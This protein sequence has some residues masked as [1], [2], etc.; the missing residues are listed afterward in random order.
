M[1]T[2]DRM[3]AA[4]ALC[5]LLLVLWPAAGRSAD[6]AAVMP[7]SSFPRE[8]IAVETR[9]AKRHVFTAWRATTPSQREQ[10]LMFVKGMG[11]NEA[12]IFVYDPP[13]YVAMWMKNT[14]LSLDML[15]VD[16]NGCVI[17]VKERATPGSLDT[18]DS[19]GMVA[20][21]VELNAGTAAARGIHAGDR[22]IRP[23]A[24]WPKTA[25]ACTSSR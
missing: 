16:G 12:M 24:A 17:K 18:I 23:G 1:R 5:A 3:R 8:S 2:D 13:S 15:F 7:L 10:G 22:V 9:S 25:A 21:V 20:L 11:D 4:P 14:L 6:A 19:G